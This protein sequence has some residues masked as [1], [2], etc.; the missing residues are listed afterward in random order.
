MERSVNARRKASPVGHF[1]EATVYTTTEGA[2]NLTWQVNQTTLAATERLDGRY[3][4]VTNDWKLSH[5]EMF[6]LYRAKYGV[7]KCFRISKSDLHISPIFLHQDKRIASMLFINML[8]LLAYT[9]LQRQ[10]QQQGLQMTTRSLLQ[11]LDQLTLIETR[12]WDGSRLHRLT[13]LEPELLAILHLVA[14][15]LDEMLQVVVSA[16]HSLAL[17]DSAF[18]ASPRLL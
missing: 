9:L 3:L 11:R 1:V 15:A 16:D 7:E 12:C 14:L 17:F 6:R 18:D 13:P 5:A 8:A 4:L 10:I 2:L